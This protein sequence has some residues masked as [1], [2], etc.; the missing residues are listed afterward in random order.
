MA[1]VSVLT[2][3]ISNIHNVFIIMSSKSNEIVFSLTSFFMSCLFKWLKT[4]CL[5]LEPSTKAETYSTCQDHV[6]WFL[7]TSTQNRIEESF[8]LDLGRH[9]SREQTGKGQKNWLKCV[10]CWLIDYLTK[11]LC[12]WTVHDRLLQTQKE[13]ACKCIRCVCIV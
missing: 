11:I 10:F 13:I 4:K 6:C 9:D 5:Y 7:F 3:T 1:Y 2:P 12:L 8:S